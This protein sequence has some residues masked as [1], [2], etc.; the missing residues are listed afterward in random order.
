[1]PEKLTDNSPMPFG[2]HK[3]SAMVNVPAGYLIWLY[4][5]KKDGPMIRA[6]I[7]ENLQGL[8]KENFRYQ[9]SNGR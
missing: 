5:N 1:M 9:I 6:Y 7:E 3:N 2:K 4:D 8:R